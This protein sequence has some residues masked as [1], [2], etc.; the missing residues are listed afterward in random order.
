MKRYPQELI[1]EARKW[2]G[3]PF[4]HQGR[5]RAGVDCAGVIVK[6]AQAINLEIID[7][8]G[9]SRTPSGV[10]QSEIAKQLVRVKI[11]DM[12]PGDVLLMS[13]IEPQH[14]ALVTGLNPLTILHSFAQAKKVVEH[15]VDDNMVTNITAVY[16]F[17][18]FF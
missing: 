12:Q 13:W 9:Y 10:L 5:V 17:K 4:H 2:L 18:E 6:P 11:A 1:D 16:R 14:V 3:T 15:Q 7:K 8:P